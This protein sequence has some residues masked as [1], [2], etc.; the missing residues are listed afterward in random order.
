MYVLFGPVK[1]VKTPLK[2]IDLVSYPARAEGLGKYD[3][4]YLYIVIH[5]QT[6][7]LYI[8]TYIHFVLGCYKICLFVC[9]FFPCFKLTK[10]MIRLTAP[11]LRKN[12]LLKFVFM[13]FWGSFLFFFGGGSFFFFFFICV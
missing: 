9:L 3:F 10:N 2:K 1:P 5:R 11:K 13:F 8:H 6:V 7:S 12:P 4:I